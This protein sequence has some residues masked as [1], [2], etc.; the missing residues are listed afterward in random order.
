MFCSVVFDVFN[1]LVLYMVIVIAFGSLM[2][3]ASNRTGVSYRGAINGL[4]L[5]LHELPGRELLVNFDIFLHLVPGV[6]TAGA[7]G[8]DE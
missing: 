2:L 8:D 3:G 7:G 4:P 6:G 1:F 5:P